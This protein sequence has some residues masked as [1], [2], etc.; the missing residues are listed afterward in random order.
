M[1]ARILKNRFRQIAGDYLTYNRTE[2]RGVLVL[3]LI[4]LCMVIA[5]AVIP[6]GT[7]QKPPDFSLF[8]REIIAFETAWQ[9]AADSDSI[10]R[11]RK[12][13]NYRYKYGSFP[14]DSAGTTIQTTKPVVMIELNSADTFDLQQLRGIGPGFAR[15]IVYYRERLRGFHDKRQ[16]LEVFGMDSV[17]YR[18]IENNLQV[19][20]DSIHPFD[21]NT[22]T[23]KE[24]LHHP[25][26]P[27][28]TTKNIMVYRQKHKIFR[29]LDELKN[30]QGVNDSIF[31]R[32]IL[33]LRLSP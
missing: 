13:L 22:V 16:V 28:A 26:F 21:L 12:Y 30:I 8:S 29:N 19:N 10:A 7:F 27:F 24:L 25:Y 32:M 3:S 14:H 11:S 23:F 9:K 18:L 2:Q 15:R 17:R 31:N 6:S 4:L 5:N 20:T 1:K 33:Y